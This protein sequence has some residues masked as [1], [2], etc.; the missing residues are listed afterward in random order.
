MLSPGIEVV[1]LGSEFVTKKL[2]AET[3]TEPIDDQA[4]AHADLV[5]APGGH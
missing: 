2:I 4:V 1:G 5:V 3:L